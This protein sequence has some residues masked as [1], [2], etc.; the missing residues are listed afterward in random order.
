MQSQRQRPTSQ[1]NGITQLL[2]QLFSP[3]HRPTEIQ[4]FKSKKWL[5]L[6]YSQTQP[7]KKL[8]T[9]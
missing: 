7:V 3:A 6:A 1:H 4:Q 2:V 5:D 9:F 8:K